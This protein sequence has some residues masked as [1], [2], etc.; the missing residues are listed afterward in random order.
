MNGGRETLR[1]LFVEDN[2]ADALLLREEFGA[3]QEV[4]TS[5]IT[6]SSLSE[7][8]RLIR[9]QS[10]DA[11]LLDLSLPDSQ[12]L[13]TFL[14][15][16]AVASAVPVIV[17]TG[18]EDEG[19]AEEAIRHGAQDYLV[20]GTI[21]RRMVFRAIRYAIDRKKVE[22]EREELL[23][24]LQEAL[25]KVKLLSGLLPICANC[26]RI[27]DDSGRWTRIEEYISNRSE[28][29]FTHG[30]C[31]QCIRKLYPELGSPPAD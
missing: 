4:D 29:D 3:L 13:D 7:G 31:P 15:V 14:R 8:L 23:R 25:S 12:G 24:E 26:K 30:I 27:R 16:Q 22:Q 17:L 19:L 21:D 11:I 6:S 5:L 9:E 18:R 10:F 28:A 20:K 2:P 1:L